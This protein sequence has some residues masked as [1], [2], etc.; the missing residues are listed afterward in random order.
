MIINGFKI[1][2]MAAIVLLNTG[3]GEVASSS[4]AAAFP[5]SDSTEMTAQNNILASG[6]F[7]TVEQDHPTEGTARI[8]NENGKRYLEFD[9]AFT[10]AQ[11]PDVKI[12][13][14]QKQSIPVNLKEGE[15]ITLTS[16]QSFEGS[17]RYLLPD[18][19]DLS[20]Y[21]SV[22]IWC[23]QFNVTFGYASL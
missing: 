23:R 9:S 22:G 6:S 2:S 17:Q 20:Q 4:V 11:G 19:L 21:K 7:M 12:V 10:T 8:V 15:Y 13:F 18:D 3:I 1:V 5:A 14:H 16:L